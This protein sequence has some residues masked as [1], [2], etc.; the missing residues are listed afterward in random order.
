[1]FDTLSS[2]EG[3]AP[4]GRGFGD[5]PR[6]AEREMAGAVDE[7]LKLAGVSVRHSMEP[8]R[9]RRLHVLEAGKG[10]AIV[11]LHG[12]GGGGA[13]WFS[14]LAPL[15]SRFKV[16]A[17]D[18]PGF[19]FS[20]RL[21]LEPPLGRAMAPDL[22]GWLDARGEETL[23]VVGTSLGGLLALRLAQEMGSR[24]RSL[25]L[26]NAAG[27][28]RAMPIPV[29]LATVP[30]LRRLA[31]SC[32]RFGL[33]LLF[34]TYLTS[35]PVPD[36]QRLP[37]LDFLAASMRARGDVLAD[38]LGAFGSLRGQREVLDADELQTIE[39]P[40]LVLWGSRD[41]FLPVRHGRRA[42]ASLPDARL[43]TLPEVGHSPNWEA[44]ERVA[45]EVLALVE[46][47]S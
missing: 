30:P 35:A 31:R 15:A 12:G 14:L 39:A 2:V 29:R 13:N 25:S 43:V 23:H 27:L 46:A 5:I 37:L 45:A 6:T 7:L 20:E 17:P 26:L 10:E 47:R 33:S 32:N 3:P 38:H 34:R 22:A 21:S 9:D 24:V 40:A 28:G 4:S 16:V 44:P 36:K 19:G 41:R 42:V 1:M 18:L 11:L 8:V